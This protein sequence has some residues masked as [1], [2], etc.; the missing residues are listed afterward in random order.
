VF[1]EVIARRTIPA[2]KNKIDRN[3][4]ICLV[5]YEDAQ[6]LEDYSVEDALL[7]TSL[8]GSPLDR[9]AR[10][11]NEVVTGY[12]IARKLHREQSCLTYRTME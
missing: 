4:R 1:L 12:C 7:T 10:E 9:Q 8:S 5:S 2:G 6:Y 11:A 3:K